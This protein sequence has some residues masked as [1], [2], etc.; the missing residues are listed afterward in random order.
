[1][2]WNTLIVL[3]T[4]AGMEIFAA[5]THRHVMHGFGWGWHRSHHQPRRQRFER[6]DLY[7]VV[8]ATIAI[9]L[10]AF[11]TRGAWPLQWIGAG[12]TAYGLLYFIVHDGLVHKRWPFRYV[13]RRGYLRRLY[14]AH[15]LHHAVKEREHG[16]S[17]G[18]LYAPPTERLKAQLRRRQAAG[19]SGDAATTP[20]DEDTAG[21][22]ER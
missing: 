16:L 21:V 13:P 12:M 4:I 3:F 15:R 8:F 20:R 14:V 6:N 9:L 22:G 1:M 17:F 2:L 5:L 7:A 11:G 18:F 19:A 10:I